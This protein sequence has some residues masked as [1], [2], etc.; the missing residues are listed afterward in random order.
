MDI[1]LSEPHGDIVRIEISGGI[2]QKQLHKSDE[3]LPQIAGK[4]VY[5]QKVLVNLEKN[6]FIDSSG[7]NWLLLCH[8]R[9]ID[10]GGRMVL[11]SVPKL[12]SDVLAILR[13][14]SV[15]E[16]AENEDDAT[17]VINSPPQD[18]A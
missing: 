5:A 15:F 13:M 8:K 14:E 9:F 4:D 6:E 16:S 7:I 11:H 3:I 10:N 18:G 17:N 1:S 12:V 2:T